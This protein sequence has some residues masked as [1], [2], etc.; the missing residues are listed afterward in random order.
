MK[1]EQILRILIGFSS[2][3]GV[4]IPASVIMVTSNFWFGL[5]VVL[6]GLVII[7]YLAYLNIVFERNRG[8]I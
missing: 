6:D 4:I 2:L 1:G 3:F 7:S 5:L 8:R